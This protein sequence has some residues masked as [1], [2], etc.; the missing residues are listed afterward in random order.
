MR[1][2]LQVANRLRPAD[3]ADSLTGAIGKIRYQSCCFTGMQR[4]SGKR[5]DIRPK[6]RKALRSLIIFSPGLAGLHDKTNGS[7]NSG[8]VGDI[9]EFDAQLCKRLQAR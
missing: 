5:S 9:P 1:F 8:L 2:R 3:Y 7:A 6:M 4:S